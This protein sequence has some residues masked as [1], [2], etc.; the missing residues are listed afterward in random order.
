MSSFRTTRPQASE[1]SAGLESYIR[2]VPEGD[3]VDLLEKQ[4]EE[5]LAFVR[6][7]SERE[8]TSRRKPAEWNIK[9]IVGHLCDAERLMSC[10]ALRFARGDAQPIPGW[11]QD[12]YVRESN[13]SART[14]QDLAEEFEHLR[15]A[16]LALFRSF[17]AE[18]YGRRGVANG[19]EVSVRALLYVIAGHERHHLEQL[20]QRLPELRAA[21]S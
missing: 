4:I 6:P 14:L 3:I 15:R 19:K 17:P 12:D 2:R 20:R 1:Y 10:R 9:E 7:L 13:F 18:A 11:E 8:A 16:N 5:T 21:A